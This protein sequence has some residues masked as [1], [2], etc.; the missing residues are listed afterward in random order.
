MI[1]ATILVVDDEP[2]IRRVLRATLAR[3]GY[4]VIEARNGLEAVELTVKERPD[5]ILLDFNMPEMNG[6]ETCRRL[7]LSFEGPIIMVTVRSAQQD[8]VV[9]LDSG[10]DDYVVKP[11]AIDELKAR[12]RA[13]LRRSRPED[14]FP[15]I[16]LPELSIDLE[17]R[18]VVVRGERIH[19]TPKEFDVLRV[20]LSQRGKPITH[21]KLLRTVWGPDYGEQTE[22]L[23]AVIRQLRTKI[24]TNPAQPRYILTEPWLGYRFEL[25]NMPSDKR[26]RGK[27]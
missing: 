21:M 6:V 13:A 9:A 27:G 1:D 16:D 7:R 8:K 18:N 14:A 15:N 12:I 2:Q 24:E 26:S 10:A 20:L 17:R 25:P 23:R 5:L 22:N 11:F 4:E 3:E 19:L